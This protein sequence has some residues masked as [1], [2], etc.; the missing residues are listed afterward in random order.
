MG[1]TAHNETLPQ[2]TKSGLEDP[3]DRRQSFAVNLVE[4]PLMVSCAI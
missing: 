4:N 1:V 3:A 2:V